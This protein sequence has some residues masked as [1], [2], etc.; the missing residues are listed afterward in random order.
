MNPWC[1]YG[2]Y[3]PIAFGAEP[4]ASRSRFLYPGLVTTPGT[5]PSSSAP[6]IEATHPSTVMVKPGYS[7]A[8][9]RA[10]AAT[11]ITQKTREQYEAAEARLKAV[12]DEFTRLMAQ[13]TADPWSVDV[14]RMER[15][16]DE[17][18]RVGLGPQSVAL[19]EK[20]AQVRAWRASQ[21][22]AAPGGAPLQEPSISWPFVR[23]RPRGFG[24]V[25]AHPKGATFESTEHLRVLE[26]QSRQLRG[27]FLGSYLPANPTLRISQ[28][29][30]V[31]VLRTRPD[32]V[33]DEWFPEYWQVRLP[34][35]Q[36]GWMY[37]E[38]LV[39]S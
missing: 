8:D 23:V 3:P 12:L 13:A 33:G 5:L 14:N 9:V 37:P 11:P 6:P 32:Y 22:Q 21:T 25:V 30:V 28:N 2:W 29:T 10:P 20:A 16:A 27:R 7:A 15:L 4:V 24:R 26:R 1:P 31:R 38:E 36:V 18:R 39:V 34:T 17:M 35:G 19:R